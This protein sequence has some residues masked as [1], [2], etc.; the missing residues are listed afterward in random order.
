MK[1]LWTPADSLGDALHVLRLSTTL[2]SSCLLTTPWAFELPRL[3]D[4]LMFHVVTTGHCWLEVEGREP[5]MLQP[6]DLALVPHGDGHRLASDPGQ[7]GP[8]LFDI[9]SRMLTERYE[10]IRHGGGGSETRTICGTVGFDHPATRQLIAALPALIVVPADESPQ[11]EWI[12]SAV[13]LMA[14]EARQVRPGGETVVSRLADVLVIQAIRAWLERDPAAHTGWLGAL[15]DPQIGGALALIHR[16][17]DRQWTVAGLA[18][19]AAM[20]RSAFAARFTALVGESP[21]RYIARWRMQTAVT[22]LQEEDLT[23]SELAARLGYQSEAAFSR[24]F[25]RVMGRAPGSV[26]ATTT[27]GDGPLPRVA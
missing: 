21:M 10:V 14:A 22:W 27:A 20:S 3:P 24:A 25:K 2:Y 11:A 1:D 19:F 26:R 12:R 9:P 8:G 5:C 13:R 18:D 6:G 4:T 23:L 17:L 7:P 16:D 15:R